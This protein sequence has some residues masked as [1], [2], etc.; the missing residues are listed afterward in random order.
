MTRDLQALYTFEDGKGDVV[1]DR[2]GA[3]LDLKIA[4]P[5]GVQWRD[6]VLTVR[7]ATMIAS[8][9]PAK[10]IIEAVKSSNALTVE[11]WLQAA[12][13]SQA[14]PA[15][16]V[17]LSADTS[18]RNLTLGQDKDS[19]DVRLRSQKT[20]NNGLP[21]TSSPGRSLQTRLTHVV[22][23]RDAD[24]NALMYIDGQQVA[25]RRVAGG[26]SNWNGGYRLILANEQ[27]KDRP[28]LGDL[29]LVAVY[30]RA[31]NAK[32][33][34]QNFEAGPKDRKPEPPSPA[35]VSATTF[36][37]QVAPLFAKHCLECHDS[38]IRKGGLDLSRQTAA[39][40][41]GESGQVIMPGK[42]VES[43]LWESVSSD[44]MPKDRAPLSA[45]EKAALRHWL[46]TGAVWTTDVID[47]VIYVHGGHVGDVW[48]Q[49][50]TVPEYI[51]TVRSAV[52]VDIAKEAK[53]LLPPDLRADGFRNT[54]Y[55]LNIDLK[56]VEAYARLAE[57][58]VERMDVLK[59]AARFSKSRKLSTDDTMRDHVAAMGKWLFRGPLAEHEVNTY[60]GIATTVA[61]A[62]GDF[63]QAMS[64]IIEAM[65]Q[66]PRFIYRIENQHGG[67]FLRPVGPY[68]LA[69]RLS[70]ILWGAPPDE[71][72]MKAADRGDLA[73]RAKV[74]AQAERMLKDPRAVDR[75]IQFVSD[76]LN[77]ARLDNMRPD[78]DRFPEWDAQLA[79]D[80][81]AETVAF[82]RDVVW[83][84]NRP[85]SDLLNA[86]LTHLTP[87]LARHYGLKPKEKKL[88][89][90][91]LSP[92]PARGGLLTQG[93][94]LTVGGDGAS[95]VSRGLFVLHDL[96][97]GTVNAPPP[98]VNT[99][100]PPTK[101][102]LT[103]RG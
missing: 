100:P 75:S 81:R 57:I 102:G 6:G 3:G 64:Y 99:T 28:W 14:G 77:L 52:G 42:S 72:L 23:A 87:G 82:F 71:E 62:G 4:D 24:G 36:D 78:K 84:Q 90:Y 39:L 69:S 12:N 2:S 10:K 101:A 67:G 29:H 35:M 7:S 22:F 56:H 46:D 96:L 59:F 61:S 20:D 16:I 15:R 47:P 17:S 31:L 51:E 27:T 91:D 76:W 66:S 60:S 58:I 79:D 26:F 5:S 97:R 37:T 95:M 80:M 19:W 45:E 94:I 68:E 30:S 98:C 86:Q 54:A 32:E 1:S 88:A 48:V 40:K 83:K 8:R 55:N 21:S 70:Y 18:Q 50:L 92:V 85:L 11:A 65:L 9:Q 33:V 43:L 74:A 25:K 63:R 103:Q 38:A 13:T 34:R 49:R 53:Q 93:S 44:E 89:V 41:G 73:D